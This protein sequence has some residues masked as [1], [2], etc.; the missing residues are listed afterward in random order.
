MLSAEVRKQ[1][2]TRGKK[3]KKEVSPTGD[4]ELPGVELKVDDNPI[5]RKIALYPNWAMWT[6]LPL[7][8][9]K[10]KRSL[11][12]QLDELG[13]RY[14][15]HLCFEESSYRRIT[16]VLYSHEDREKMRTDLT[17]IGEGNGRGGMHH[18]WTPV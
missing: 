10:V 6:K 14:G 11:A 1:K 2:L 13:A 18:L 7:W 15:A 3:E 5:E 4:Y 9:S 17:R 8:L 12:I 16:M